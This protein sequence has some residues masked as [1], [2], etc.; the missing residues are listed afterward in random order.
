[1]DNDDDQ[2]INIEETDDDELTESDNGDQ[3]MDDAE[4]ND[5]DKV[6]EEKDIDQ[7]LALYEQAKDYQESVNAEITSMVDVQIQQEMLYVPLAPLPDVLASVVPPTPT[8]PTPPPILTIT[9]ITTIVVPTSTFVDPESETLSA[10]QLRVSD[11]EKEVKEL[12]QVDHSTTLRA[13]I[14]CEVP[15]AVNEYLGSKKKQKC[16]YTINSFDKT[17]L[18]EFDQKQALF[19]SMHESKSFNKHLVNKT[20]YHAHIESL[21]VNENAM[22]QGVADL[23]KHKKRPHNDDR[24]QDPPA[25]ADQGLKKKKTSKDVEPFKKLKSSGSSKDTTPCQLKST[26]DDLGNTDEQPNVKAALKQDWFKKPARPPA[27]VLEWN[28]R[29]PLD[30][31]PT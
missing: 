24:D 25:R 29:K 22:D 1:N 7:E 12:K 20:L 14:R 31:G 18:A 26:G 19:D 11:L 28:T 10:L 13:S 4:K 9:T 21:I 17:A 6:E 5:E 3:E 8:M 23:I 30:D 27:P 16:Q 15:S 2:S